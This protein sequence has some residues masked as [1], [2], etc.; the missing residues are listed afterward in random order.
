MGKVFF[1]LVDDDTA[2]LSATSR[3]V[4]RFLDSSGLEAEILSAGSG[5]AAQGVAAAMLALHPEAEWC[6]V[7]D[8][9]MPGMSGAELID[10]LDFLLGQKLLMRLVM[11]GLP[12]PERKTEIEGK[13]AFIE[14]KPVSTAQLNSYL[15]MFAMNLSR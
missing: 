12:S 1:L 3:I 11:T 14:C 13:G 5:L 2:L 15:N 7:T 8:Y 9:D 4:K 10:A 6:L